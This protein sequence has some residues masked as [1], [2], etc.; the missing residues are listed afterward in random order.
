[1]KNEKV[2]LVINGETIDVNL[3][4]MPHKINSTTILLVVNECVKGFFDFGGKCKIDNSTVTRL[5]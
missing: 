2:K 4:D 3:I 1:M 5:E